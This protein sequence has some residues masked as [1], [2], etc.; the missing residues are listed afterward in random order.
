S[1]ITLFLFIYFKDTKQ[2]I[3]VLISLVSGVVILLYLMS[4]LAQV[5]SFFK[6][7]ST[8]SNIDTF[9]ITLVL[10]IVGITY[11]ASFAIEVCSEAGAAGIASRIEVAAKILIM[12]IAMPMLM[13]VL[14]AILKIM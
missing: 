11:L 8:K 13:G 14:D 2:N 1:L 6:E 4:P 5:L 3:A 12:V 10:K 7:I 9:Y